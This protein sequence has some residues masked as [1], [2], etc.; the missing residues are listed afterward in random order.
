MDVNAT[1]IG[2]IVVFLILLWFIYKVV[3]PMMA[4]P[5]GE[6][7]RRIADGLAAAEKGQEELKAASSRASDVLRE[8]RERARTVDEQAQR[9]ASET[10]EA[11]KQTARSEGAR[12]VAAARI[13]VGNEQQKVRDQLSRDVGA[14]VVA[15]AAKLLEREIDP[16][17]HAQL[18]EQLAAD[19]T[20]G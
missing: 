2:Q 11:A 15:G 20:R 12:L 3:A 1:F 18:L 9:R 16:R 14:L 8:A 10:L 13:E 7:Q 5:I 6:R 19:I 17:A 4:G